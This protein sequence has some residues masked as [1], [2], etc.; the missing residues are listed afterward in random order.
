MFDIHK[1]ELEKLGYK[2]YSDKITGA[3]GDVLASVNPYGR[4]ETKE[5][6]ILKVLATPPA[7]VTKPK[8]TKKKTRARTEEGHFIADDPTT[9]DI[10]EAWIEE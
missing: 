10:N 7:P 6:S 9:P 5:A 3:K 8:K 2:V 1:K 4:V